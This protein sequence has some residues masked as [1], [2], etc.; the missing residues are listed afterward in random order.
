MYCLLRMELAAYLQ[1]NAILSLSQVGHLNPF[2]SP[3]LGFSLH[4]QPNATVGHLQLFQNKMTNTRQMPG[5]VI[6]T[7]GID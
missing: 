3:T 6:G 1:E 7:L 5:G 2:L 4:E